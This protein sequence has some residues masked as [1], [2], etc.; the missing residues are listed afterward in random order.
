M[1]ELSVEMNDHMRLWLVET[2]EAN[3]SK[4]YNLLQFDYMCFLMK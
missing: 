1:N 4:F 3:L 2:R